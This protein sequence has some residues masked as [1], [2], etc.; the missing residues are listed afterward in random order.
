M[1]IDLTTDGTRTGHQPSG[2]ARPAEA[3][4]G[5]ASG[6]VHC[7][8]VFYPADLLR[9]GSTVSFPWWS[10]RV[11]EILRSWLALPRVESV[12]PKVVA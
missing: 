6:G 8:D 9:R 1:T 2:T 5:L 10:G 11:P 12:E 4:R 3:L 7:R